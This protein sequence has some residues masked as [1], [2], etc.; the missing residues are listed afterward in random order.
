M[1]LIFWDASALAKRY[2]HETGSPT[3]NA[4]FTHA[5]DNLMATTLLNYT[6]TYSILVRRRNSGAISS[7]AFTQAASSLQSEG[8]SSTNFSVLSLPD[9]ILLSSLS[10]MDKHNSNATDAAILMLM[11]ALQIQNPSRN[12]LLVSTDQRFLRAASKEGFETLNPEMTLP[13][14]VPTILENLPCPTENTLR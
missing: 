4:I 13:I 12:T 9:D 1:P 6:E 14:H 3:V 7:T 5:L 10:A 2:F 8:I 11:L